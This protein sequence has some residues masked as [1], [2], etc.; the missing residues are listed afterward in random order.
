MSGD[1]EEKTLP[2]TAQKLRKAREKGQTAK[3]ADFV[4]SMTT[5]AG[6]FYIIFNWQSVFGAFSTLFDLSVL[7]FQ[8]DINEIGVALFLTV[9]FELMYTVVGFIILIVLIGIVANLL[10]K[11]GIPFSL[12]PIKPDFKKINPGEG[13]KRLFKKRNAIEFSTSFVKLV[14]WFTLCGVFIWLFLQTILASIYCSVGCVIDSAS[15]IGTLLLATAVIMLMFTGLLDL[16]LQRFLFEDEQKM[17]HQEAKRE[18]KEMLGSP[19]FRQHRRNEHM[20]AISGNSNSGGKGG[21]S[22]EVKDGTKGITLIIQGQENAVG[23]YFHPQ[24]AD[25][26]I[27]VAK[28]KGGQLVSSLKDAETK[29]IPIVMDNTLSSDIFRTVDTGVVIQ[30]RHFEAVARMLVNVGA[31]S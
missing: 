10:D 31:I 29:G 9:V 22:G 14:L 20:K 27:L 13:L 23:I 24:H 28:F 2:P 16:P 19:E 4:Q 25:V 11:Q 30:Q 3:S 1:S 6:I 5:I 26:P 15:S 17:G 8:K 21:G 12:D 7:S 18:Q